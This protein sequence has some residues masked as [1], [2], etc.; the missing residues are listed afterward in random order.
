MP[1]VEG[2][3]YSIKSSCFEHL[4][5]FCRQCDVSIFDSQTGLIAVIWTCLANFAPLL[6]VAALRPAFWVAFYGSL[7]LPTAPWQ[8]R[9]SDGQTRLSE[10]PPTWWLNPAVQMLPTADCRLASS[11]DVRGRRCRNLRS[12]SLSKFARAENLGIS[13][14]MDYATWY[15]T[16]RL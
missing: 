5:N 9:R 1:Q 4:R 3:F 2:C 14:L 15:V 16:G 10:N 12:Q 6:S 8:E 13:C 11:E 7:R